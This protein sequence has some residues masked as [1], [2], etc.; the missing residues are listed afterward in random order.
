M[1]AADAVWGR[2]EPGRRRLAGAGMRRLCAALYD[3]YSFLLQRSDERRAILFFLGCARVGEGW[4]IRW[5]RCVT[6][7]Q[8][9]C[10]REREWG[11]G[12]WGV[13]AEKGKRATAERKCER[14]ETRTRERNRASNMGMVSIACVCVLLCVAARVTER[15][16]R[17]V[18]SRVEG[19]MCER[20][21]DGSVV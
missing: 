2:D 7:Q 18:L 11:Y 3:V 16:N 12:V 17:G 8:N 6:G 15:V 13:R 21:D 19:G 10:K 4:G 20:M 14:D 9:V 1:L 5:G